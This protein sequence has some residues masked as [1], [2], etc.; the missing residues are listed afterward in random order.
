MK[1]PTRFSPS[2]ILLYRSCSFKY[3]LKYLL[4]VETPEMPAY[5][6]HG[7]NVHDMIAKGNFESDEL[8][9]QL[10]LNV[11]RDF[12]R[13]VNDV[14]IFETEFD[15]PDNP[16]VFRGDVLGQNFMAIFD[17]FW[18]ENAIGADWKLSK[19]KEYMRPNFEIQSYILN[20]LFFQKYGYY[21]KSFSFLIFFI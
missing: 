20:Q 11:A 1:V 15:D 10:H 3:Y 16:C 7:S 21:L 19:F 6:T 9:T 12:I 17:V 18:K 2:Q 8:E 5:V 14:P 4:C 13:S